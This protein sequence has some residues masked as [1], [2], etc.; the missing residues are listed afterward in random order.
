MKG[1][2]FNLKLFNKI[3]DENKLHDPSDEGYGKWMADTE[4]DSDKTPKVFSSEFNLNIFNNSFEDHKEETSNEIIKY[5]EPQPISLVKQNYQE[6]GGDAPGDY[7][8]V[9]ILK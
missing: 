9:L 2:N 1:N 7:S 5:Q 4:Y 8:M 6:L 3:Y